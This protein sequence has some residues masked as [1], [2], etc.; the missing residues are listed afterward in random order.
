MYNNKE[1]H[2]YILI[3]YTSSW[4]IKAPLMSIFFFFFFSEMGLSSTSSSK[5]RKRSNYDEHLPNSHHLQGNFYP[6]LRLHPNN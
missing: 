4:Q 1:R 3:I 6:R 2:T 5:P